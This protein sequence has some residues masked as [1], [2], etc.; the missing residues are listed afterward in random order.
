MK[1]NISETQ[2]KIR[3]NSSFFT[4]SSSQAA[5]SWT[6]T[7]LT[8]PEYH[9]SP[10]VFSAV[11]VAQSLVFCVVLRGLLLCHFVLFFG[12]LYCLSYDKH[13]LITP[14]ISSHFYPTNHNFKVTISGINNFKLRNGTFVLNVLSQTFC[15]RETIKCRISKMPFS[16]RIHILM[17]HVGQFSISFTIF[18][19]NIGNDI[20]FF[21]S[22]VTV[23]KKTGLTNR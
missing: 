7:W 15:I 16:P 18:F 5:T 9:S 22:T 20:I 12:P 11:G 2:V 10:L 13:P 21:N 6:G 23:A 14:L 17:Y 3:R 4:G 8:L 19:Q 1:K